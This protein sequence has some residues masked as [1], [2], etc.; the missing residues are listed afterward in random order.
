MR[1]PV[2]ERPAEKGQRF[3]TGCG[4]SL[5]DV[6]DEATSVVAAQA[7]TEGEWSDPVWAPT[8]SVPATPA[9]IDTTATE[10]LPATQPIE[11]TEPDPALPAPQPPVLTPYD[12]GDADDATAIVEAPTGSTTTMMPGPY[13]VDP[14]ADP[15]AAPEGAGRFRFTAVLVLGVATGLVALAALFTDVLSIQS[16]RLLAPDPNAP[17]GFGTGVWLLDDLADNLSVAGLLAAVAM[18][19]G[20]VASGF[21]WKWGGGL[22]GGGG[23]AFGGV[24]AIAI[25]LAQTPIDA[26]HEYAKVPA[27]PPFTLTITRDLGYHLLIVAAALGLVLFFTS[28]NDASDR[29]PGLNPWVAALGG[30]SVVITAAGPLIPEGLALFSDNWYLVEAPGEPSAMLLVGRIIQL[31]ALLVTGLIGFLSVRRY[32]VG[33]AVG[34]SLPVIWMAASTLFDLTDHPVGP[35]FRNPGSPEID[36]HGVTVIGVAALTS[37]LV[38]AVIAAYDQTVRERP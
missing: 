31:V 11:A 16:D 26:A 33:L 12:Y 5:R 24:A 19:A 27:E 17:A 15:F 20:G 3:C 25:G 18:V 1:C 4:T 8:G 32:G 38:L 36:L 22:A 2:C 10:Q 14:Y 30:L 6:A 7:P 37:M 34:G 21:G 35:A 23:L 13:V 9:P 29:R 28:F